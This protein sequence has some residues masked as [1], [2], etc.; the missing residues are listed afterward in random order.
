MS[1]KSRPGDVALRSDQASQA[2]DARLVFIGR[3]RSPWKTE[4]QCPKNLIQARDQEGDVW[5]EVEEP[6]RKSL[7]GLEAHTHL[8]ILYWM[9]QARRDLVMQHPPHKDGPIGTFALRSPARPNPIAAATVQLKT[10]DHQAGT[11]VIDAID[12][13]DGT[14]LLDIKPWMESIDAA[15]PKK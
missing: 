12:C 7:F 9:N 2:D 1:S 11:L 5:L 13:L 10:I 6:W 15:C 3:V 14:P 8:L 4:A